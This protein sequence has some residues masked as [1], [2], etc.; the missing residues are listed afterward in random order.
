MGLYHIKEHDA[1]L[2]EHSNEATPE[3]ETNCEF[4][5]LSIET[6]STAN[7]LILLSS[8]LSVLNWQ[9]WLCSGIYTSENLN[10]SQG[11]KFKSQ[12]N[13][14]QA[15]CSIQACLSGLIKPWAKTVSNHRRAML[16]TEALCVGK[17][18]EKFVTPLPNVW[19]YRWW[20]IST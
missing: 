13:V 14:G 5:K 4:T 12:V 1:G 20:S 9:L 2:Q 3:K 15:E 10:V 18:R 17:S 7:Y 19:A 8:H 6:S 11:L 16:V